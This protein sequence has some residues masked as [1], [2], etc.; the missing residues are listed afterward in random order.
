MSEEKKDKSG[1]P[2]LSVDENEIEEVGKR[3]VDIETEETEVLGLD[4][5]LSSSLSKLS[6]DE[7]P[8][9]M[10]RILKLLTELEQKV[11]K[12]TEAIE[13]SS[14]MNQLNVS[15]QQQVQQLTEE[16]GILR[17]ENRKLKE[18]KDEDKFAMKSSHGKKRIVSFNEEPMDD[19]S[20]SPRESRGK[21]LASEIVKSSLKS[22]PDE[23][24]HAC[25]SPSTNTQ[26]Q[27]SATELVEQSCNR[28]KRGLKRMG[29]TDS[30]S[31][32]GSTSGVSGKDFRILKDGM[33]ME[34]DS[35]CAL[36]GD[37]NL[38]PFTTS[39][40]L[41]EWVREEGAIIRCYGGMTVSEFLKNKKT[42]I[43]EN[44][45]VKHVILNLGS[46]DLSSCSD[47][48]EELTKTGDE[49]TVE[50]IFEVIAGHIVSA[51]RVYMDLRKNVGVLLPG[52]RK[53]LKKE[54]VVRLNKIC[55]TKLEDLGIDY[56]DVA[57]D[58]EDNGGVRVCTT[59]D[60]I[61]FKFTYVTR[62]VGM[63]FNKMGLDFELP[64]EALEVSWS[65]TLAGLC[66][67]CGKDRH[68]RLTFCNV[69]SECACCGK[70]GHKE[71]VCR[72]R[73]EQCQG[74]GKYGHYVFKCPWK[75]DRKM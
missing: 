15:L 41:V 48:L 46:N 42:C 26:A 57:E 11:D 4:K 73:F 2:S 35:K 44:G 47:V 36:I 34:L 19:D 7:E 13:K 22:I 37:S 40:Q 74:C 62:I 61:H 67:R 30:I 43:P 25:R 60:G 69:D 59:G 16:N 45:K 6:M 70:D 27:L 3:E 17:S 58:M 32:I 29:S 56:V 63:L 71:N 21:L 52:H 39:K 1:H 10:D 31:S 65:R 75:R 53:G 51:A 33:K 54:Y 23:T 5:H 55:K 64:T 68:S 72:S 38:K 20:L 18:R 9:A 50:E 8:T 49:N 66:M 28:M 12:N 14:K 24:V